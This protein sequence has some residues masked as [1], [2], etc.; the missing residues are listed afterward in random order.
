M[1]SI[2]EILD[3]DEPVSDL[4]EYLETRASLEWPREWFVL[5]DLLHFY[6][7]IYGGGLNHAI[8][9]ASDGAIPLMLRLIHQYGAS[10]VR[11]WANQLETYFDG[12]VLH[13]ERNIRLDWESE[14]TQSAP[15]PQFEELNKLAGEIE[16]SL[17]FVLLG[18]VLE[19]R[20]AFEERSASGSN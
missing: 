11:A 18:Y 1:K 5:D 13:D 15:I 3:G 20:H 12:K 6:G 9:S 2:T 7:R 16:R 17:G 19:H 14:Y 4:Y 8:S 10:E